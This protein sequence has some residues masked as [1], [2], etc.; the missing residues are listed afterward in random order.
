VAGARLVDGRGPDGDGQRRMVSSE[1]LEAQRVVG[2][3]WEEL[4]DGP[5]TPV[6]RY[7]AR[8]AF[9]LLETVI[10]TQRAAGGPGGGGS[11]PRS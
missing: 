11:P 5:S 8:R 10:T 7:L 3:L 6:Q 9:Y 4:L 1:L 2:Q